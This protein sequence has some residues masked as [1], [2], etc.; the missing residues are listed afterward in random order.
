MYYICLQAQQVNM[1][2][3]LL[4]KRPAQGRTNYQS[5]PIISHVRSPLNVSSPQSL[6]FQI[7]DHN[8]LRSRIK[9]VVSMP[10]GIIASGSSLV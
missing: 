2:L 7:D 9:K 5:Q 6:P 3:D 8:S 10:T 1:Q 4:L